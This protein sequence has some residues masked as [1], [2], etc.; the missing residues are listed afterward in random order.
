[1]SNHL[2]MGTAGHVDHGKTSLIQSLTGI[3]CDTH[4]QEKER[5][6]TINLGFAHLETDSGLSLGIVDVPGHKDFIKTMVAGVNGIDFVLLVIAADS[7]VMPQTRE[8][9][10]ILR[11]LGVSKG[12]IA[13]TK[14]DLADGE[15]RDLAKLEI[16]E[17]LENTPLENAPI[18]PVS[19]VTGEGIDKLKREI[20]ATASSISKKKPAKN[21]RL[22]IDR[23]FN[24]KGQGIVVTGSVL[25]GTIKAGQELFL[26]PG[27]ADK[28]RVK[29][30]QR[31]GKSVGSASAGDRAALNISGLKYDSFRR[32]M[33]LCDSRMD[34]ITMF[35]ATVELFDVQAKPGIWSHVVFYTGTFSTPARV[36][37]LTTDSLSGNETAVA[38]FL[39]EKPAVLLNADKFIIR[40][41]SNDLTLGGGTILDIHPLHHRRRTDKLKVRMQLLADAMM[42]KA[43]RLQLIMLELEKSGKPLHIPQLAESINLAPEEIE[44]TAL[45]N[46]DHLTLFRTAGGIF[47]SSASFQHNIQNRIATELSSYH[48]QNQL[49]ERG[50]DPKEIKGKLMLTAP[51]DS[52]ILDHILQ[53]MLAEG[54]IKSVGKT[55]ALKSHSAKPDKKMQQQLLWLSSIV[56]KNGLQ[57]LTLSE[58]GTKATREGISKG[59]VKMLIQYLADQGE[60][61]FN[62][63]DILHASAVEQTRK[64][65]LNTLADK[66]KGIN[67]KEFRE[68]TGAPKKTI[69]V[70]I[71]IF[72]KEGIITKETFFLHITEKGKG[73]L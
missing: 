14:S 20:E 39:L 27:N 7:G 6:I 49:F 22:Y 3:D 73:K 67:E 64:I 54:K 71:D 33:L 72:L 18:V 34:E 65:L 8:H 10:N 32:G 21:F 26:L 24:V 48:A 23:I 15:M 30:I 29:S 43:N 40:N 42:N 69:Q 70:L 45:D 61:F 59:R 37:L 66:P 46:P 5:G 53:Q 44:P 4:K 41:T 51:S 57:R 31:H 68:L 58:I 2:I 1:M 13:L 56:H 60:L 55:Y 25:G 52:E 11:M 28:L 19:S 9:F 63:E 47:V 35:D 17:F 38:Q 16:M 62:G 12:V 50:L 36:H